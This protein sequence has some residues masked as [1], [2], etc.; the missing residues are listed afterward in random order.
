MG[1]HGVSS[2]LIHRVIVFLL[3][4]PFQSIPVVLDSLLVLVMWSTLHCPLNC[5]VQEKK[6]L[7]ISSDSTVLALVQ[8]QHFGEG[9]GREGENVVS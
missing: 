3:I 8:F 9:T 4:S 5:S 6:N 1:F 2:P 7:S